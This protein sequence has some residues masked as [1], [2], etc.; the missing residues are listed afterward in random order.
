MPLMPNQQSTASSDL[1]PATCASD[2]TCPKFVGEDKSG[3]KDTYSVLASFGAQFEGAASAGTSNSATAKGG[4]A[5]YFAT[6][7]AARLLAQSGGAG[8]VNTHGDANLTAKEKAEVAK[9]VESMTS[10]LDDLLSDL[11]DAADAKKVD[12]AKVTAAF[13]KSPG[14]EI[15]QERQKRI[16]QETQIAAMRGVLIGY[17]FNSVIKPMHD[18][19]N[20]N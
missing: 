9:K 14:K 16:K 5:Q 17:S 19:L 4:I 2:A 7:L 20:P 1:V 6:G 8:L 3:Q 15:S 11:A 13:A 12:P 18:T 10:V